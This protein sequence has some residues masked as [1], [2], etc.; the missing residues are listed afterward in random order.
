MLFANSI[1]QSSCR[2]G[3]V[4]TARQLIADP[5]FAKVP[6]KFLLWQEG[7]A[8]RRRLRAGDVLCRQGD[9]GNTA[10]LIKS[11]RLLITASG[12]AQ[13]RAECGPEHLIVGEMSCL[14][15]KPRTADITATVDG[16]VWEIRRNVLDRVMR[17]P[18]MH[19]RFEGIFRKYS[20]DAVLRDAELFR[21]L[22]PKAM[23]DCVEFLRPRLSFVRVNPGQ[24]LFRQNDPAD[25]FYLV[26]MGHVAV[27]V[28]TPGRKSKLLQRGPGTSIGEIGLLGLSRQDM[29]MPVDKID[30]AM[31]AAFAE[32]SQPI[33]ARWPA[34]ARTA[35]CSA[36]DHLEMARISRKDFL[37]MVMTFPMLRRQLI[38]RSIQLLGADEVEAP[39]MRQYV[40]QGL[41]QGQSLLVLDLNK[42]TRC[43]ECTRACVQQHGSDSHG[44]PI[45]RMLRQGLHFGDYLVAT[46]CRSCKDAYCMIGCPVDAIHRGKHQQIVIEDH[47]IG[48]GLCEKN[49]PYGNIWMADNL[50]DQIDMPSADRPG[51]T[52]RVARPKAATCD[53]CDSEG[54][55]DK[56]IPRCVYACPHDAAFRMSGEELLKKVTN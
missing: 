1:A 43:D 16:E 35:T 27:E 46:A 29:V 4:L 17:S 53:L 45:T 9:P 3:E 7:L 36:L 5:F 14:S 52:E 32:A 56:P 31:D 24:T 28:Q 13:L 33:T 6:Y 10:Y 37:E 15:G 20:L 11:G 47:C 21:R 55:L 40:E 39:A 25:S 26:R 22:D 44:A 19:E 41:Y 18:S 54:K 51:A 8:L 2:D 34:S 49:C 23:G 38:G 48:C 42:C 50:R 12:N 30:A